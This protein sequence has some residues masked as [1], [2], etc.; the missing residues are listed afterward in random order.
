MSLQVKN[1][2]NEVKGPNITQVVKSEFTP[3]GLPSS[4][5]GILPTTLP[6]FGDSRCHLLSATYWGRNFVL[7][8]LNFLNR[9]GKSVIFLIH[10]WGHQGSQKSMITPTWLINGIARFWSLSDFKAPQSAFTWEFISATQLTAANMPLSNFLT[11]KAC[12]SLP[13][14]NPAH[15]LYGVFINWQVLC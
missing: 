12:F 14:S 5:A 13:D 6:D 10:R 2:L 3:Q 9:P 8:D 15:L 7:Y 11:N 1:R 4:R